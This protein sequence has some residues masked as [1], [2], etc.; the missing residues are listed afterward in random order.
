[1]AEERRVAV[2]VAGQE[3]ARQSEVGQFGARTGGRVR[4]GD[5]FSPSAAAIVAPRHSDLFPIP[6]RAIPRPAPAPS[7]RQDGICLLRGCL[8]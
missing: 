6:P 7:P 2:G 8:T 3:R 4:S 5:H 1:M